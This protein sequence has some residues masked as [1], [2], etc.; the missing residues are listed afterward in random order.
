[1]IEI[2]YSA[3]KDLEITGSV[4]DFDVLRQGLQAFLGASEQQLLFCQAETQINPWPYDCALDRLVICKQAGLLTVWVEANTLRLAG[5]IEALE[6]LLSYL[7]F[8][9]EN[10]AHFEYY[11]EHPFLSPEAIPVVFSA[12][13]R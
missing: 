9:T 8:E 2:R 13:T 10:H 4:E 1:M 11:E 7:N 3:P 6:A 5:P 12:I